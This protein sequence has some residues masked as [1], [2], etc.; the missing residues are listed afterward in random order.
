MVYRVPIDRKTKGNDSSLKGISSV[1][2]HAYPFCFL[3]KFVVL[4]FLQLAWV[5]SRRFLQ[6][7]RSLMSCEETQA[8]KLKT[9]TPLAEDASEEGAVIVLRPIFSWCQFSLLSFLS[10]SL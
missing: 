6:A 5:V 9:V 1:K 2:R 7:K 4:F 10:F 8:T 3:S